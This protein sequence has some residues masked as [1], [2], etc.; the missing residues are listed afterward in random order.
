MTAPTT[1]AE[2]EDAVREILEGLDIRFTLEEHFVRAKKDADQQ[3]RVVDA[4]Q[5]AAG[6][7]LGYPW[8]KDDQKNFPG[9]TDETGVCIGEH[10]EETIVEELAAAYTT[11]RAQRDQLAADLRK[12]REETREACARWHDDQAAEYDREARERRL[13]NGDWA[14][15]DAMWARADAQAH[16]EHA[17]A[18]RALTPDP[19]DAGGTA[20]GEDHA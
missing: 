6:K 11:L 2:Q 15:R 19:K 9:A 20:K 17:A 10:V 3:R 8:F 18:I 14:G 5:Q 13:P 12:A 4:C 16:R 7:A 1:Q